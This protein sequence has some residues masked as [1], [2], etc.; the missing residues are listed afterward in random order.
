M[1]I[2]QESS[3]SPVAATYITDPASK[4]KIRF[5]DHKFEELADG[6]PMPFVPGQPETVVQ[7][8]SPQ[9]AVEEVYFIVMSPYI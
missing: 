4:L 8:L 1:A 9:V 7:V 5:C 6:V 2:R 3:G